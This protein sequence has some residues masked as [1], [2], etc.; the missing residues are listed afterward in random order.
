MSEPFAAERGVPVRRH[1]GSRRRRAGQLAGLLAG[2][3]VTVLAVSGPQS[4]AMAATSAPAVGGAGYTGSIAWSPCPAGDPVPVPGAQCGT[5]EVPLDWAAPR[6]GTI[7]LALSRLPAL[8][9]ARRIGP[10]LLNPGGP[11]GAGAQVVAYDDLLDGAPELA[12]LRERFDV[13]G[14]DP[15]GVGS[16]TP[17]VCPEPLHDPAV[18]TFP[19]TVAQFRALVRLNR[20][21]GASCRTATGPLIDHVDTASVVSDL[22]AIRH[23]LG[24]PQISF[25]GLSYGTEIGSL[26]AERYPRRVREMVVDGAVDHSRSSEQAVLDEAAAT[27][28]ALTRFAGWCSSD[29]GCVLHG[30]DV[31]GLY[32]Q[33]LAAADRDGIPAAG[34]G[35]RVTG[36]ELA[37]GAYAY[38]QQRAAWPALALSLAS[39]A[40]LGGE[41]DGSQLVAAASFAGEEYD[42]YRTVGCHDFAPGTRNLAQLRGLARAVRHAAPH[43]WRYSEFWD[44]TTGCVGWPVRPAN[45]P[46]PLSVRGAPPIL[47]VNTRFDPATPYVWAER[48]A[49]QIDG[50]RLLTV[51]GDGHTGILHSSCAR[52]H[53]AKYLLSGVLPARGATCAADLSVPTALGGAV[54]VG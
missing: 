35:R 36:E 41:A 21:S 50:S 20:T 52:T 51:E 12:G 47:I 15:R 4:L 16:S 29:D 19:N 33:L 37:N 8:D 53:E 26:Y 28:L 13:I 5:L 17:V 40:G 30:Q 38:L 32:S 44:W 45:A 43:A 48:L 7:T 3:V 22:E 31:L 24:A 23:A 18:T 14:F 27:E 39:A 34:L 25:L 42:A 10:L 11:G 2:G 9:T 6:S 1:T 46:R 49:A 54:D